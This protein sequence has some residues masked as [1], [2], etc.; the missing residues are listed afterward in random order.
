MQ[1]HGIHHIHTR[2]RVHE[3]LE[4]YPHPQPQLRF[5][6]N[7]LLVIA[8]IG[9][10]MNIP[11]IYTILSTQNASGVSVL[12]WALYTIF[13]IPWFIYGVAHKVKPIII[14]NIFWF[15]TNLTVVI[16]AVKY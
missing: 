12:S 16:L 7:S 5:L 3:H 15:L 13:C 14:S 1:Q 2:K 8:V 11:Q 10:L 9:P 4:P 6:D